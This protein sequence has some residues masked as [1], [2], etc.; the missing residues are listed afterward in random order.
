MPPETK[1]T[2][3]Y[4]P[5]AR[6]QADRVRVYK[7]IEEMRQLKDNDMA[8]FQT[9]P[10]GPRSFNRYIDDSERILNGYTLSRDAQGKE[11]WQSNLLDNISRAKLRAVAA[12]V[13]IKMPEL[14]FISTNKDGLKS[15]Q[16]ADIIKNITKQSYLDSNPAL[17]AFLEVWHM[18]SHGV[19]FEY[20][21]Y[22][23]GGAMQEVVESFD[24]LTGK[25]KT[26][27]EYRRM[28]GRPFS[29][30]INPQDFFWGT[31]FVRDIQ[32]QPRL[33]WIQHYNRKELELEF[34]KY[35]NYKYVKDK[36]EASKIQPLLDSIYYEKW[37]ENVGEN[38]DFEVIRY[39]SKADEGS[40]D[41]YGYEVWIH[42]VPMLQCPLL[43][44]EKQKVYPFA[45]QISE[46]FAN[47]NF[48]V[49]MSLPGILE[50]YQDGKNTVLNTLIDKL[51]RGVNPMKLIGLQN[52]D[53]FDVEASIIS[54]DNTTYVPDINA[55][56]FMD[57]PGINQGELNMLL[58]LEKGLDSLS[59]DKSQQG[60]QSTTQKTARQAVIE[61]TRA[62]EIKS[63][64][65]TFLE[66]FWMQKVSLRVEIVLS[67][68]LKDK[69]AQEEMRGRII[70]IKD[71]SFG[72]GSR[73]VLDIYVAKSKKDRL[74]AQEIEARELAMEQQG[75]AYK[76][77]SM[78]VD[79]LDE[80]RHDFK[81]LPQSFHDQDKLARN[82][83]LMSEIQTVTT[84]FP[85]FFVAN[86]DQ[87]LKEVLELRGKHPD[88]FAP[89]AQMPAMPMMEPEATEA[90]PTPEPSPQQPET[91]GSLLGL[92]A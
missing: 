61:D 8:H 47:T 65:Y 58:I 82:E 88:E 92:N 44:G 14:A 56:K 90:A 45:K 39:Y 75:I 81:V 91:I 84:L 19:V 18:L 34:S 87:Y 15:A 40:D 71:Y 11:D 16:R 60:V 64:V 24:S 1:L 21:G 73:G 17:S 62:R 85:E 77:I 78:D 27:K 46:P 70:S 80:W 20:E 41:G 26:R 7:R 53:L 57:H 25:V 63:I 30:L 28:D 50:A 76:L 89:P 5:T 83:E 29:V 33:A 22:K 3:Q 67:H 32:D 23:T 86:K 42:G 59:V 31:F 68:W 72:D 43:W 4:V 49:G 6:E 12:S 51:Y 36:A 2:P 37:S 52:R 69:A 10:E 9:G 55:A 54:Q 48:F 35:P 74:S 38:D 79:Y 66:D 13:G